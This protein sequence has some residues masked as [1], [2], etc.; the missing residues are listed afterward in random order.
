M[1]AP[2]GRG[3]PPSIRSNE[4]FPT[5]ASG[6]TAAESTLRKPTGDRGERK[7]R[8]EAREGRGKAD[9][10]RMRVGHQPRPPARP[11]GREPLV[12]AEADRPRE[13]LV[14]AK[15]RALEDPLGR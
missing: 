13:Q 11:D 9:R 12:Q 2:P 5:S 1:G 15:A 6:G 8:S 4:R 7:R 3:G 14:V 10:R